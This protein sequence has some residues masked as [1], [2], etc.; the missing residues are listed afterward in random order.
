MSMSTIVTAI[1]N[2]NLFDTNSAS[3]SETAS[4]SSGKTDEPQLEYH[5]L[6]VK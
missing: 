6:E 5:R 4:E 2:T 3:D 1:D